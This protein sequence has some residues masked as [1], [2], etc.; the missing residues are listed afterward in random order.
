LL[1]DDAMAANHLVACRVSKATKERL[2]AAA[3]RAGRTESDL[4]REF[5]ESMLRATPEAVESD[6]LRPPRM[7]RGERIYVRLTVPD[8]R[9]LVDRAAA[10]RLPPAT[11]VS[12]L[13]RSHLCQVAPPTEEHVQLLRQ[14]I[15]NLSAVGRHLQQ[16]SQ[17][18]DR[19]GRTPESLMKEVGAMLTVC[20]S[21]R[22]HTRALLQALV[23]SWEVGYD[24][25]AEPP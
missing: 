17:A 16:L 9:H 2:R 20:T 13:V 7:P 22:D 3:Q 23:D 10:V 11:Y 12:V 5:L 1:N 6:A 19:T 25:N 4:L 18:I 15:R 14:E 21:L 8:R 24:V